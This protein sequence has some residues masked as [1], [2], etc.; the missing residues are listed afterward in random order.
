MAQILG[1]VVNYDPRVASVAHV[2]RVV[3][4]IPLQGSLL[5]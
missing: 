4:F 1:L 2:C 3:R 5:I